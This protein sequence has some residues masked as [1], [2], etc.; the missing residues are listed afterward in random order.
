LII[1]GRRHSY[2]NSSTISQPHHQHSFNEDFNNMNCDN[3]NEDVTSHYTNTTSKS[4]KTFSQDADFIHFLK[5]ISLYVTSEQSP[6]E[7]NKLYRNL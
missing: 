3:S 6:K 7:G 5:N 4:L 1:N 2:A